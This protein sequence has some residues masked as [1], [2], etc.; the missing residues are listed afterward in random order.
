MTGVQCTHRSKIHFITNFLAKENTDNDL[1]KR[2]LTYFLIRLLH[3]LANFI[4]IIAFKTG[5]C[6]IL[7][8]TIMIDFDSHY[9]RVNCEIN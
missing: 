6:L 3:S 4:D 9:L 2:G 1:P 8:L 5:I 7:I